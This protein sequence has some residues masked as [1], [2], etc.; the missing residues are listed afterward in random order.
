[1]SIIVLPIR[2]A[3]NSSNNGSYN[4]SGHSSSGGSCC[5]CIATFTLT[6]WVLTLALTKAGMFSGIHVMKQ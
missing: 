6:W 3:G 1:M 5:L 2:R 4:G